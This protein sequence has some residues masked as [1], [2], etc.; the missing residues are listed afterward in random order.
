MDTG[1][2]VSLLYLSVPTFHGTEQ[3][4]DMRVI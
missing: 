2:H 3:L 1:L 4:P